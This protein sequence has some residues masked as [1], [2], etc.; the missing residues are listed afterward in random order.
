MIPADPFLQIDVAEQRTRTFITAAHRPP[1][2]TRI[3]RITFEAA[4]LQA[5]STT[6]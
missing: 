2:A 3:E 6:C 5:F 1:D 4:P